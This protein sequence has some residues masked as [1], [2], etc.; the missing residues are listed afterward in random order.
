MV[1]PPSASEM[2]LRAEQMDDRAEAAR[3]Y[4]TAGDSFLRDEDYTN[5]TRCYRVFLARAGDD[6]LSPEQ[7]DSWLLTSLKNAAFQEKVDAP[8][9]HD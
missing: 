3:L 1:A 5:A 7:G 8:K 6:G 2:E 9:T 4:R